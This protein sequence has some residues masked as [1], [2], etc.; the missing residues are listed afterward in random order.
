MHSQPAATMPSVARR[1][2]SGAGYLGRGFGMFATSPRLMLLGVIPAV[3]VSIVY[4][5]A[6]VILAINLDAIATW[7]TP[8]ANGWV[9]PWRTTAR[10]AAGV[11]VGVGGIL[12]FIYTYAAV[13]LVVGDP[14]YERIWRAVE[15][16]LGNAP[17]ERNDGFWKSVRRAVG[18]GIRLLIPAV[19]IAILL[20]ICGF[21]P[22]VGGILSLGLGAMFGGWILA[23]ELTG[24]AFDA[25]GRTLRERRRTLAEHRA[26][27][28]GF[29]MVTY[30]LFLIPLAAIAVMPAAV[31]GAA[32][33]SRD[34]LEPGFGPS[35]PDGETDAPKRGGNE[36]D[37]RPDDPGSGSDAPDARPAAPGSSP[38]ARRR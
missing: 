2:M 5:T 33:L 4:L 18:D 1:W 25:R 21:I 27:S 29:G 9:E 26:T 24:F 17:P 38:D 13:T 8:F 12:L 30:L 32:M 19:L 14:F 16:R 6:I 35:V 31:A 28:L 20:L 23:V 34:V 3:I 7:L 22:V 11:G 36:P 15:N 37:D 10:F